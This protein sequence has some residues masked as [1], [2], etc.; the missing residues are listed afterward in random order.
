MISAGSARR[1]AVCSILLVVA[2]CGGPDS[3]EA[4]ES[5]LDSIDTS[6]VPKSSNAFEGLVVDAERGAD[7]AVCFEARWPDVDWEVTADCF[8]PPFFHHWDLVAAGAIETEP[9]ERTGV[10]MLISSFDADVVSIEQ[11]GDAAVW[12]QDGPAV[13]VLTEFAPNEAAPLEI[14]FSVDGADEECEV[15]P[16]QI[17]CLNR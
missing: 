13:V 17:V 14:G 16:P 4:V 1:L 11:L 2:A 9:G 3:T 7:G 6:A 5:D 8:E 15:G 12:I 10:A